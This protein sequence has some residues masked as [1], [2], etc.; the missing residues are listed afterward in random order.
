MTTGFG[1]W[2]VGAVLVGV[3]TALI[4][5]TPPP[6][7]MSRIRRGERA[8]FGVYRLWSETGYVTGAPT[9]LRCADTA[10][11]VN[12]CSDPPHSGHPV[13]RMCRTFSV[14]GTPGSTGN[15]DSVRYRPRAVPP[16]GDAVPACV[17][18]RE[19]GGSPDVTGD[20]GWVLPITR[21]ACG[22]ILLGHHQEVL[23]EC[24]DVVAEE[25]LQ[26][27]ALVHAQ[28]RERGYGSTP[29]PILGHLEQRHAVSSR[30]SPRARAPTRGVLELPAVGL[31]LDP[32]MQTALLRDHRSRVSSSMTLSPTDATPPP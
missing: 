27:S 18:G 7:E 9:R 11:G 30:R 31:A 25:P 26:I 28:S 6:S 13:S 23:V 14:R 16:V 32:Y 5:P 29:Q 2:D 15:D 17:I 19:R 21:C 20:T 8:L 4:D 3:G 22:E 24:A 10:A 1:A 12:R